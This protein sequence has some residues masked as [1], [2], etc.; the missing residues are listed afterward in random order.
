MAE[1]RSSGA[2][3]LGTY[4]VAPALSISKKYCS[5]SWMVRATIAISWKSCLSR[6]GGSVAEICGQRI[7]LNPRACT[8]LRIYLADAANQGGALHHPKQP[9][10]RVVH[11]G[12]KHGLDVKALPV[13][14]Y[15]Q[16]GLGFRKGE[17]EVSVTGIG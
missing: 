1:I 16:A 2:A 8:G 9:P 10:A 13:I 7:Y 12:L 11:A 3:R 17:A 6:R 14:F 5:S 15:L 4:P